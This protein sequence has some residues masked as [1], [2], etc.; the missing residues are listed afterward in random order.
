MGDIRDE[1]EV[2]PFRLL[3]ND[4][5]KNVPQGGQWVRR[6]GI[7]QG[8]LKNHYDERLGSWGVTLGEELV[9]IVVPGPKHVEVETYPG[10]C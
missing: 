1:T 7:Q 2:S 9:C 3:T 8:C 6:G 10:F 4:K 5:K